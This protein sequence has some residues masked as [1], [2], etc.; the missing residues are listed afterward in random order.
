MADITTAEKSPAKLTK[1]VVRFEPRIIGFLCWW[2]SYAASDMA[3]TSRLKYPPNV[4]IIRVMCSSRVDPAFVMR[5]F[6]EGAD[7]VLIAG[8]H[9]GECHYVSGNY[10]TAARIS[11][12]KKTLAQFGFEDDRIRLEWISAGEIRKFS[13]VITDMT[14]KVRN[15]GPLNWRENFEPK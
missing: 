1:E 8:C 7:G 10:K 6:A 11:L 12:L 15:L 4:S 9:L 13:K 14:E 2:C 3:G 5:A